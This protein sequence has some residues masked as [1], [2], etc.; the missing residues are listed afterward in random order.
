MFSNKRMAVLFIAVVAIAMIV[1]ISGCTT[2]TPTPGATATPIAS[3]TAVPQT[4]K[5]ATTTSVYDTGLLDYVLAP[6]EQENNVEIQILSRGSGEALKLGETGDVDFLIVHSPAAEQKFMDAGHG[7]NR[8]QFAHNFFVIVGPENDPAG[9]KGA[10]ATEAFKKIYE[11]QSTFVSRGD[12]SGTANK[13]SELW[14]K[15]GLEKPSDASM[16]W[17]KSTGMGMADTLRMADQLQGY[18]L[19]DKGTYLKNQKNLS[20]VILMEDDPDMINKYS[21]I[22]VNQTEHPH[23]NYAMVSKLIDYF[24]S[25]ETQLMIDNYGVDQYGQRL[26]YAD[27]L[28][29]TP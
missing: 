22:A 28:N 27:L 3:P 6:F 24:Q 16:T 12:N 9:I 14:N 5:L 21:I 13:E 4:I 7:W 25:Q 26:F 8:T 2:P 18:T 23:V 17:Y 20:L 11:S 29:Q 19:S 15:T 1:T 10:S